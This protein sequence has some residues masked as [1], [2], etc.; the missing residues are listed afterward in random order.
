MKRL[1]KSEKL[2]IVF[3]LLAVA[4]IVANCIEIRGLNQPASAD[5]G[6]T[7]TVTVKAWMDPYYDHAQS[8][9]VIGFM[10]PRSWNARQNMRMFYTSSFD[11]GT[12]S[13]VAANATPRGSSQTWPEAIQEKIGNGG[14]YINDLEWI[15]FQSDK[16]YDM[17][18][19][20]EINV[21]VTI[22]VKVGPQNLRVKLGYFSASSMQELSE[23]KFYGKWFG[24]CFEVTNGS[25]ALI[26]FCSPQISAIDPPQ[27]TDNDIITIR[28][29]EDAIPTN[30]AGADKVF[31]CAKAFTTDN[32][33]IAICRQDVTTAFTATGNKKWRKDLWPRTYFGLTDAQ[34]LDRMEY[35]FTDQ[36]GTIK[37][38]KEGNTGDPF[39]FKFGCQ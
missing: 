22:K 36:T 27:A 2:R 11:N 28:Y 12:M 38:L 1:L 31:L 10:A 21:D 20:P 5:A 33:E 23:P 30:L 16:A 19:L 37:V 4:I 13:P 14:N 15:V 3:F 6:D 39:E 34:T 35:Y 25:G 32:V 29:D 7:L 17:S 18:D 24:D 8:R 26:D 9:L